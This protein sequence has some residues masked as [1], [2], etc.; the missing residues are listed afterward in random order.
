MK[1]I[2]AVA[3]NLFIALSLTACGG[4]GSGGAAGITGNSG[5]GATVTTGV[6]STPLNAPNVAATGSSDGATS[7]PPLITGVA[8]NAAGGRYGLPTLLFDQLARVPNLQTTP[9]NTGIVGAAVSQN[10]SCTNG[11]T[12]AVAA[13]IADPNFMVLSVGDMLSVSF[14]VCDELGIKL[15]GDLDVTLSAIQGGGTYDGTTPFDITLDA[16]FTALRALDGSDYYYANGDMQQALADGGTGN[17]SSHI[18]GTLLD[19]SYNDHDQ[20]LSNYAIDVSWN[21]NTGDYAIGL[22]GTVESRDIDGSVTFTTTG[23]MTTWTQLEAL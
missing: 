8:V 23:R 9:N 5:L 22:D 21:V 2:H 13:T 16:M 1:T 11:G 19:T 14:F 15:D 20:K 18:S 10:V 17:I 4:G 3:A 6:S 12:A 7:A